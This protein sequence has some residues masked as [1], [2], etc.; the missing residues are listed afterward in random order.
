M[1]VMGTKA[2]QCLPYTLG[3]QTR[4]QD[5]TEILL[6][7]REVFFPDRNQIPHKEQI[8]CCKLPCLIALAPSFRPRLQQVCDM[9][10]T[11]V[12]LALLKP[13]VSKSGRS[14]NFGG[15]KVIA[16]GIISQ[17]QRLGFSYIF[18]R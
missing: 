4:S 2:L 13:W 14:Q 1:S 15:R 3:K 7:V 10:H 17:L 5:Q 12:F 16:E 8:T 11:A 9:A 6:L 18:C